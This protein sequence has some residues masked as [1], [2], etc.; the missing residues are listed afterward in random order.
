M[1]HFIPPRLSL[2][3]RLCRVRGVFYGRRIIV[4]DSTIIKL[5]HGRVVG[6]VPNLIKS[7]FL[8]Y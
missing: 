1:A 5:T 3:Q 7:G 4:Q 8:V 2:C 6:I